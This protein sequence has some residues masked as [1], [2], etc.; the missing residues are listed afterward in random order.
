MDYKTLYEQ[1]QK[2]NEELTNQ[3]QKLGDEIIKADGCKGAYSHPLD[4]IESWVYEK[5]DEIEELKKEN[6][7]LKNVKAC[8]QCLVHWLDPRCK[9]DS[10]DKEHIDEFCKEA[11]YDDNVKKMLYDDFNIDDE[12][13]EDVK[14]SEEPDCEPEV[15][16][17]CFDYGD[18][19]K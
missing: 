9:A 1:S 2:E 5:I 13:F 8:F 17:E 19:G 16:E 18:D 6:Q 10:P 7:Q 12:L 4:L 11:E 14:E 15:P 3:L